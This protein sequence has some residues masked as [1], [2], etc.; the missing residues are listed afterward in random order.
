MPSQ[1]G[2]TLAGRYV[3]EAVA[4]EGASAK[5]Y[6]AT[7]KRT[8]KTVAVKVLAAIDGVAHDTRWLARE[9]KALAV[10]DHPN[11]VRMLDA[12][13]EAEEPWLCTEWLD[14]SDLQ[15]LV[16][17]LGPLPEA[18][19]VGVALGALAGLDAAH[20][21]TILHRD[22][23][24]ANIFVCK[25]GR[26]VLLDFGV[27]RAT[28]DAAGKTLAGRANTSV[29]GTPTYLPPELL[30]EETATLLGDLYSLG[31]TLHFLVSGAQPFAATTMLDLMRQIVNGQMTPLP[32]SV[33]PD[34]AALIGS[35]TQADPAARIASAK[36]ARSAFLALSQKMPRFSET[37]ERFCQ[38]ADETTSVRLMRFDV[39]SGEGT[40]IQT[41]TVKTEDD[42]HSGRT[43]IATA[44]STRLSTAP[45]A[46]PAPRRGRFVAAGIAAAVVLAVVVA[47][48]LR[49][50]T[51]AGPLP[52][53]PVPQAQLPPPAE[54]QTDL[55]APAAPAQI[56]V[57]PPPVE[58]P[59]QRVV[60]EA[61]KL[62][63]LQMTLKQWANVKIDGREQGRR[64]LSARF[65]LP[66][67]KHRIVVD[68]PAYGERVFEPALRAG[69]TQTIEVD[70]KQ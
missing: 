56:E 16:A 5:V 17:E 57:T 3:L 65:E 12:D 69:Q 64:Q 53:L 70:F 50:P 11:V 47:F 66:P 43:Q 35:M 6:R 68:N 15:T 24:P 52:V 10:L 9:L 27:A 33:S 7:D 60:P 8:Q 26:I 4:G 23:K 51:R 13:A 30:R 49:T 42:T 41:I 48:M 67:G 39:T 40:Q 36:R 37:F 58:P 34:L 29:V 55:P 31:L 54:T 28:S 46:R 38:R 59:P 20:A 45:S 21:H 63:T 2:S 18:A 61:P 1:L 25:N 19:V 62:A 44:P 22:L 32:T 14:G